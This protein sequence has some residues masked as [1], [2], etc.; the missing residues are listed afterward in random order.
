M[1]ERMDEHEHQFS[2]IDWPFSDPTNAVA[3]STR[4]VV[5]AGYPVLRVSHDFDWRLA[6]CSVRTTADIKD[7][8]VVSSWLCVSA[9]SVYRCSCG[10]A[11]AEAGPHGATRP[12]TLG[13]VNPRSPSATRNSSAGG[14][15]RTRRILPTAGPL[16]AATCAGSSDDHRAANSDMRTDAQMRQDPVVFGWWVHAQGTVDEIFR[17]GHH[18]KSF[19][20][21]DR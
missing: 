5:G 21:A 4:Q 13:S 11:R 12:T 8:L 16:F 7:A 10:H 18:G 19:H 2:V 6:R 15:V 9:Q 20:A 3:I 14:R 1:T 17:I